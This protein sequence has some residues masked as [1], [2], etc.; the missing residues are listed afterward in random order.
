[1]IFISVGEIMEL[2]VRSGS[3]DSRFSGTK[4]ALQGTILHQR[5]QKRHKKEAAL[6]GL[7]YESEV[8][9]LS[10]AVIICLWGE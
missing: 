6:H 9:I 1:M 2:A 5:L 7:E 8:T 4:R 3:I 10:A